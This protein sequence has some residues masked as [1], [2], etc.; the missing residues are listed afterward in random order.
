MSGF[1]ILPLPLTEHRLGIGGREYD[2]L[3][4][5]GGRG[6]AVLAIERCGSA[7]LEAVLGRGFR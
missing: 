5:L 3:D 4:L 1:P 6:L 2:L 7:R